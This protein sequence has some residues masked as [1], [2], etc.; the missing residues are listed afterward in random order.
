MKL[1]SKVSAA[2][3]PLFCHIFSATVRKGL[4]PTSN[5]TTIPPQQST[6]C[7]FG[8]WA[9]VWVLCSMKNFEL[10]LFIRT[11]KANGSIY[12]TS[13][14]LAKVAA[15][16]DACFANMEKFMVSPNVQKKTY[17]IIRRNNTCIFPQTIPHGQPHFAQLRRRNAW[18]TAPP[19]PDLLGQRCYLNPEG[20]RT[21]SKN[22]PPIQRSTIHCFAGLF[23]VDQR[24]MR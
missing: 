14:L 22:D 16:G 21:D 20:P 13:P 1:L 7:F 3:N 10:W 23:C 11:T 15:I 17:T 6:G 18:C 8:I 12:D 4:G 9:P 5:F 2:L 24:E 19:R